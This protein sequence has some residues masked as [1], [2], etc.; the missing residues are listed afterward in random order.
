M[1]KLYVKVASVYTITIAKWKD[2]IGEKL[3]MTSN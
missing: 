1:I 2:I 3:Y